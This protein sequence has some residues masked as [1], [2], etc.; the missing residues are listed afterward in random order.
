MKKPRVKGS[1]RSNVVAIPAPF[2]GWNARDAITAMP[3]QDAIVLDNLIPDSGGIRLRMGYSQHATGVGTRVDTLM[4]WAGP[5]GTKLF[6]ASSAGT[7]YE[8]SA[9][10]TAT[11]LVTSLT[12]GKFQHC[13]HG[14]PAGSYLVACN[15]AAAPHMYDGSTWATASVTGCTAGSSSFVNVTS[16][17]S[18]L[19]FV[20]EST[21]DA[22]YLPVASVQGAANRLQLGPFCK[23]GGKLM[24]IAT[25]TRDGGQ[26]MDDQ[27]CFIT[28][29]GEAI[30]YSGTDPS[31]ATLWQ[32]VGT[33]NIPEPVGRRCVTQIGAD[34]ALITS[35]GVVPLSAVLPLSPA[36]AAKVAV[37]EK[38]DTA[39]EDAYSLAST[40]FGW[41]VVENTKE[42]LLIVNVP[43]NENTELVQFVMNTRTG[44]WCRWTDINAQCWSTFGDDLYFGGTDG[45]VYHYGTV[46]TDNSS[47]IDFEA[48]T[49]FQSFGTPARKQFLMA[50]PMMV[51]PS[52]LVPGVA[53]R[54]DYDDAPLT[55]ISSSVSGS[56]SLWDVSQ[57]D[58]FQWAG[59][60]SKTAEGQG[61]QGNTIG[62]V[63]SL[64]LKGSVGG[65]TRF[66]AIEVM[67]EQGGFL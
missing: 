26:G 38:I 17:Q 3:P 47:T 34:L 5:A 29:N 9:T 48:A 58:S 54:V 52:E 59:S 11:S 51:A 31:S 19:W 63:A 60:S 22:W 39:F 37:T 24:A 21:L 41:Q 16:H 43:V 18:R 30:L 27:I 42:R 32:K 14:T 64:V 53:I 28:S 8:V 61:I 65:E 25:W 44:A 45:K 10:A 12:N 33:F 6:A 35:Q 57:W 62:A 50:K 56:G 1:P 20:Q 13:M 2:G 55:V 67:V 66:N 4:E 46:N 7:I 40:Y 23:K 36:G 15:G 49:A